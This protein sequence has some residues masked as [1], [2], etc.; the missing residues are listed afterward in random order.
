MPPLDFFSSP[1]NGDETRQTS[2]IPLLFPPVWNFMVPPPPVY[3]ERDERTLTRVKV[4]EKM[5]EALEIKEAR[6]EKGTP[7]RHRWDFLRTTA[8]A[9]RSQPDLSQ[10]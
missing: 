6:S 8:E 2:P 1:F 10:V 9:I 5:K 3:H 4:L 7:P